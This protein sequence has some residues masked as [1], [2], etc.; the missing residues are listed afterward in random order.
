[1][2]GSGLRAL[3]FGASQNVVFGVFAAG[4]RE[5]GNVRAAEA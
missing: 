5:E 4:L 1:M 3:G 2:Q